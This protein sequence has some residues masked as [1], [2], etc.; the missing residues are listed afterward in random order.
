MASNKQKLLN[1]L[2]TLGDLPDV[3]VDVVGQLLTV[4]HGLHH[5]ADFTFRWTDDSHFVGYF[6]N[7]EVESQAIIS[8]WDPMD[9]IKFGALYA[10]L[11]E[12]RAMRTP[13]G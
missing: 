12:L 8:L 4:S 9:A 13:P 5:T 6:V 7:D 1:R 10:T 11:I 3:T 2:K